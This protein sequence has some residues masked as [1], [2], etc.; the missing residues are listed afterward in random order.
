MIRQAVRPAGNTS[1]ASIKKIKLAMAS[2]ITTKKGVK[3]LQNVD[4]HYKLISSLYLCT[5]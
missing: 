4:V 1:A 3:T 5:G 2:L